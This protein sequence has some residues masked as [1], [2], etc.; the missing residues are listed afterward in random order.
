MGFRSGQSDEWVDGHVRESVD[1][2]SGRRRSTENE[3]VQRIREAAAEAQ[4]ASREPTEQDL[5][6]YDDA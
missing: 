5:R 3:K 6:E 2:L 4:A 1:G